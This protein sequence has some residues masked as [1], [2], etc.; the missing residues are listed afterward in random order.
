MRQHVAK[1]QIILDIVRFFGLKKH[2]RTHAF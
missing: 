1:Y 2:G